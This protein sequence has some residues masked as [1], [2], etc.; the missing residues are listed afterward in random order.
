M[1]GKETDFLAGVERAFD[2]AAPLDA[3]LALAL[4]RFAA[5]SGTI[6]LIQTGR[7]L[8]L[9]AQRNIPTAVLAAIETIPVG[10]GMAGLAVERVEPVMTCNLQ[11][12]RSGDV[13]PG[14]KA[15]RMQGSIVVPI[16]RGN[17]AIGALG[18][19]SPSERVFTADE[20]ELLLEIGRRI[21][22]RI[23]A[24]PASASE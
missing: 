15:T 2:S 8:R 23:G 17:E 22:Q 19:A 11:T 14:A 7:T 4:E 16:L 12:D 1:M 13:R 6:H 20:T 18:I 21:A 3:V 9:R 10:K 24:A 5:S